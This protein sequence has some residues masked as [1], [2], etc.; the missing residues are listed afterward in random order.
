MVSELSVEEAVS[1]SGAFSV[2]DSHTL[3]KNVM[4]DSLILGVAYRIK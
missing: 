2:K 4:P 1:I 3:L